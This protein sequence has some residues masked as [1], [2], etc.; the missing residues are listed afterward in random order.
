[1]PASGNTPQLTFPPAA[2]PPP[3]WIAGE[4]G[5]WE[6]ELGAT[7]P[8]QSQVS[9]NGL[10]ALWSMENN[11]NDSKGT[12]NGTALNGAT[13]ASSPKVGSY[14]GSFDGVDDE[15]LVGDS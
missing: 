4:P 5:I 14:A 15:V 6:L 11:W 12:N 1:M 7:V 13:F 8:S 3:R 10:V 2:S 9:E